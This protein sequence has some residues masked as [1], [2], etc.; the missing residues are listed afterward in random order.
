[1]AV[2]TPFTGTWDA[3]KAGYLLRRTTMGPTYAEIVEATYLGLEN[4]V[5]RLLEIPGPPEPPLLHVPGYEPDVRVGQTWVYTPHPEEGGQWRSRSFRA[6]FFGWLNETEANLH[7]QMVYFWINHFAVSDVHDHRSNYKYIRLLQENCLGNAREM[8]KQVTVQPAMLEF[9]NGDTN[10]KGN[11]NEN[12]ARELLELFTI[13]KG[14]QIA[15]GDYTNYTEQDVISIARAL[16]GWKNHRFTF[17][18]DD[19]D[20]DSYY[21]ARLHDDGPK[22]LSYHFGNAVIEPNGEEE[23]KDVVDII[24]RQDETARSL[25]RELYRFFVDSEITAEVERDIIEPLGQLLY[26]SD[27]EL[28]PVLRELLSSAHFYDVRYSRA[29]VKNPTEFVMSVFRPLGEFKHMTFDAL[30]DRYDAW[31]IQQEFSASMGMKFYSAP[32]VAGWEAY[33]QSPTFYRSWVTTATIQ[34]RQRMLEEVL[35]IHYATYDR[36]ETRFNIRGFLAGLSN[37]EDV[38]AVLHDCALIFLPQD[39][40]PGQAATLKE[41]LL[42]G[43]ASDLEW[44]FE[45]QNY[46][47]STPRTSP[48][49]NFERHFFEFLKA[50]CSMLEFQLV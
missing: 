49:S 31:M 30:Q 41:N 25:C 18:S 14:Q 19:V 7:G 44:T 29:K 48:S 15:P 2:L 45:Y 24:F 22:R 32:S 20:V 11:P 34:Q 6:W 9:Q 47:H 13:Q 17:S 38:N 1:M 35:D 5:D 37:P 23:Y 4:V 3:R 46:T 10:V 27:Y 26:R 39:L 21:D 28:K 16:T 36:L 50:M 40:S 33:H 8:V 43:G 42:F 12:Y